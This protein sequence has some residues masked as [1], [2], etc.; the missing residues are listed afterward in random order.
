MPV[1]AEVYR[2]VAEHDELSSGDIAFLSLARAREPGE[3]PP[4][5]T[6]DP[7]GRIPAYPTPATLALANGREVALDT[8]FALVVTHSCELDRQKN[9]GAG[10]GHWDCRLAVAP[11]VPE[12]R[13][14]LGDGETAERAN[15]DAIAANVPVASLYI[16]ALADL[17]AIDPTLPRMP[18]PRSFAD[19]RGLS[20]VSR[21]MV[22]ADRVMG[23]SAE[24]L[25]VLQ[26]QLARFFTWREIARHEL[27]EAMV[28]RR[29]VSALPAN[30][31]GNRV[32]VA[33]TADDGSSITV[34][35]VA[36]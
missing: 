15:W 17:S 6:Y 32:S 21:R 12:G 18:W 30:A 5:D 14:Q 23:L 33:L 10:E 22:Q 28:G 1:G 3:V 13:V 2:A 11:I 7:I 16:P 34:E 26:R 8:V 19:L 9:L 24:Y 25:G 36:K 35:L 20:T 4:G 31:K 29:I 27:V